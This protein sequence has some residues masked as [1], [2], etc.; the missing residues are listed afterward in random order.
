[1]NAFVWM[2]K[3]WQ[4]LACIL[5]LTKQKTDRPI[6]ITT[7]RWRS[8]K[9]PA[10]KWIASSLTVTEI[11][12]GCMKICTRVSF[13]KI[14]RVHCLTSCV[15][16]DLSISQSDEEQDLLSYYTPCDHWYLATDDW[17]KSY[18]KQSIPINQFD[19]EPDTDTTLTWHRHESA[20]IGHETPIYESI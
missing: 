19:E 4:L 3:Q 18:I 5:P 12:S 2:A 20:V 13:V 14:K 10:C 9:L 1:M 17:N 15:F 11:K 6:S 7:Q 8:A 16:F